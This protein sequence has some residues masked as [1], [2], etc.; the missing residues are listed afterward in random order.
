M[1]PGFMKSFFLTYRSFTTPDELFHKLMERYD[2]PSQFE[3]EKLQIRM[4]VCIALKYWLDVNIRDFGHGLLEKLSKFLKETLIEDGLTELADRLS[5]SLHQSIEKEKARPVYTPA[6]L[7]QGEKSQSPTDMFI[8]SSVKDIAEQLTLLAQEVFKALDPTELLNLSW[9]KPHLK[10]LSPHV[11]A[12]IE[13][14]N[15]TAH[16]VATTIMF[17][18]KVKERASVITKFIE[19]AEELRKMHNYDSVMGILAGL[20]MSAV[21]RLRFSNL[22]LNDSAVNILENLKN[23]MDPQQSWKDYRTTLKEIHE[24]PAI[25]YIGVYLTDLTFIEDGNP[26]SANFI[27]FRKRELVS[28]ILQEIQ[29]FKLLSYNFETI[30]PLRTYLIELPFMDEDSLYKLSLQREPRNSTIKDIL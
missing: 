8:N 26:E 15:V 7:Y 29:D 16:W 2:V 18:E 21:D 17:H 11:L 20:N 9:S 28:R 25:P 3:K 4:R 23:L 12:M 24:S 27:N 22:S 5:S 14:S 30:E 19:I 10:H 1:E 6:K 13:R